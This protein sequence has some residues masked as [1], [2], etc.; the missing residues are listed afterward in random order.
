[1]IISTEGLRMDPEKV[2]VIMLW[3]TPG[4]LTE[5]QSFIGFCNFYRRFIKAFSK[6][7]KPMIRLTRKDQPFDWN[8]A[9]EKAFQELKDRV[10]SAPALRHFDRNREA[11]LE[12]DS[13]DHVNGGVLSQYDDDGV[14]HPVAFYSKNLNPAEC[15]YKIYNKELLTI[16]R[17]LKY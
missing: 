5:V 2:Q 7:V 17:Y 1:M 10:A 6:I 16:I 3:G 12:A 8:A 14:L 15:N 4:N 11:I 9:C 13:S